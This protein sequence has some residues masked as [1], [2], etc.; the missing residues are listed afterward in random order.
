M[1]LP[2]IIRLFN[3]FVN[4]HTLLPVGRVRLT[5]YTLFSRDA[6]ELYLQSTPQI[7]SILPMWW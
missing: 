1:S 4:L 6:S 3:R 2:E 7:T 5:E